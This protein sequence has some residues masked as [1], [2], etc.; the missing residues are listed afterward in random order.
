[1]GLKSLSSLIHPYPTQSESIR[2][3][4]DAYNKTRLSEAVKRIFRCWFKLRFG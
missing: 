2:H 3:I 4:A 1:L